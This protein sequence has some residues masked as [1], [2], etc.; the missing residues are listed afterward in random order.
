MPFKRFATVLAII[1]ILIG[2]W[3]GGKFLWNAHKLFG[4][5][6]LSVLSNTKLKG[7]DQGRVNILLA[8]NSADDP[9]HSG[10]NLTDSIMVMSIDTKNNKAFLVSIPRDLWVKIPGD[11]HA[12]INEAYMV[13]E[14]ENFHESGYPDGGMGQLE[15]IVSQD[16]DMPIHYYALIDYNALKQAVDAV[17][18]IDFVVQSPDPRG[19]YDPNIDWTNHKPLVKLSNGTHHLNGQQALDLARARGDAYNSYGFPESDF[20]RTKHQRQLMVALKNKA[21]SAGVLANPAKLSSLSDALGNNV[22][23]DLHLNEVR[24]L[25][26]LTK[27]INSNSIQSLSFNNANGKNLLTS[28][29]SP[30]GQSALIPAAGLDNFS[31][32]QRFLRKHTSHDPL[33]Q[34]GATVVILNGT[35]KDGLATKEKTYV[36]SKNLDVIDVDDANTPQTTTL[37]VDSSAGKKPGTKQWLVARYGNNVTTTSPYLKLYKAD[38]IVVLG[39]DRLQ[40]SSKAQ[41]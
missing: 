2:A 33:V 36:T 10:A 21:V 40:T 28:Y 32:I 29:S 8:G 22:K 17:G 16:L 18:G 3:V 6:I 25:Y 34:E 37:I 1:A 14:D 26:D 31:D 20:D 19:L 23:T 5:N 9:G 35:T 11:G 7:E 12:K 27:N 15:Q 4:G 30:Q 41:Q 13:G 24:R 39:N 38:F